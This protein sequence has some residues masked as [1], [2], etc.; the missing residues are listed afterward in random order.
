MEIIMETVNLEQ[1]KNALVQ[2]ILSLTDKQKVLDIQ[3]SVN[4][5]LNAGKKR[6][7]AK[8]MSFSDWNKQFDE[9]D[10]NEYVEDYGMTIREF[11]KRI[12]DSERESG[13]SK[14]DFVTKVNSW[15]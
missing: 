13:M 14:S 3:K 5:I 11:R 4:K 12:Y 8:F 7:D 9:V 1:Q 2:T 10:L 6:Y 15:K